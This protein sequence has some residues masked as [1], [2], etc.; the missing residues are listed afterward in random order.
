MLRPPRRA[1]P[2]QVAWFSTAQDPA[3]VAALLDFVNT[4]EL[5][6]RRAFSDRG[7]RE[8]PLR[9]TALVVFQDNHY[10]AFV[11]GAGVDSWAWHDR[12]AI[13]V[14]V[15]GYRGVVAKCC[16]EK[17]RAPMLPYL[18]IYDLPA[19]S[20]RANFASATPNNRGGYSAPPPYNKR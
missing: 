9:L 14:C 8:K 3:D 10:T 2:R 13:V 12:G 1:P 4:D 18:L 15:G 16:C 17:P 7:N 19:G 5:D 6:P 11:R 20:P